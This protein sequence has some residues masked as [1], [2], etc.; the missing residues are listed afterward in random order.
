MNENEDNKDLY[1]LGM[2]PLMLQALYNITTASEHYDE[3][4]D[5]EWDLCV[6]DC[7]FILRM[8]SSIGIVRREGKTTASDGTIGFPHFSYESR[9][10]IQKRFDPAVLDEIAKVKRLKE[11]IRKINSE[12]QA[13]LDRMSHTIQTLRDRLK[14]RES[15]RKTDEAKDEL[16]ANA[17]EIKRLKKQLKNAVTEWLRYKNEAE[18]LRKELGK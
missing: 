16:A 8:F 5:H 9:E 7:L 15:Q 2:F 17:K 11:E 1:R 10:A 4:P 18:Y 6:D 13:T 3:V 12:H 14:W